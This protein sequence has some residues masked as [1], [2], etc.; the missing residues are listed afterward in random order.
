MR[1]KRGGRKGR[2]EMKGKGGQRKNHL[3]K[4]ERDRESE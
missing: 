1:E 4:R 3:K 2:R